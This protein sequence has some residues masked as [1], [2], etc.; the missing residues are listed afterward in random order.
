[1]RKNGLQRMLN[2][3]TLTSPKV[4]KQALHSHCKENMPD[5]VEEVTNVA[6]PLPRAEF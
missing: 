1:M 4:I 2:K 5:G 3:F 6:L